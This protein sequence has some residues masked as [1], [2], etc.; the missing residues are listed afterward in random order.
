MAL[1]KD[2]DTLLADIHELQCKNIIDILQSGEATAKELNAVTQFLKS[3]GISSDCHKVTKIIDEVIEFSAEDL[4]FE[5]TNV[6]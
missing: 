6:K 5:K 3:N 4:G 2:I 1:K